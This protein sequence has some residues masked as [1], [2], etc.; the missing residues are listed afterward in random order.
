MG[1][2]EKWKFSG[3]KRELTAG[4]TAAAIP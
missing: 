3:K 4:T 2:K 1:S